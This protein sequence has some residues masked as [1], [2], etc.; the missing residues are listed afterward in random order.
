LKYLSK[1]AFPAVAAAVLLSGCSLAPRGEV[2]QA[3]KAEIAVPPGGSFEIR[4][5]AGR[6]RVLPVDREEIEVVATVH[7]TSPEMAARIRLEQSEGEDGARILTVKYP[8]DE[9]ANY[10]YPGEDLEQAEW[11]KL[12]G[13]GTSMGTTYDGE[14]VKVST[15]SGL[16]LYAD[17]EIRLPVRE[18][19]GKITNLVG[20]V[21]GENLEGDLT[22]ETASGAV[23]IDG[24]RGRIEA[25][26][27]YGDLRISGVAGSFKG[28]TSRGNIGLEDFRGDEIDC[29]SSYGDIEVRGLEAEQVTANTSAGSIRIDGKKAR[30]IRAKTSRGDISASADLIEVFDVGNAAGRIQLSTPG[31]HLSLVDAG[32]SI[33]DVELALGKDAGFDL[34]MDMP[35]DRVRIAYDGVEKVVEQDRLVGYRRGDGKTKIKLDIRN[36][37]LLLHP[38]EGSSTPGTG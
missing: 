28:K 6:I 16:L 10:L 11:L 8:L 1:Q 31:R 17:L 14:R 36:G 9:Y 23:R 19:R 5:M 2:E 3:L 26:A 15:T 27:S 24:A 13:A 18:I 7:A 32:T 35:E 4:N 34:R 22:F 38:E 20:D 33:G 21:I 37:V 12:L 30:V 25:T 29:A